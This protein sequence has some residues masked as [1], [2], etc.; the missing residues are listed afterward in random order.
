MHRHSRSSRPPKHR[1]HKT[2]HQIKPDA[3]ERSH[4][5]GPPAA[6]NPNLCRVAEETGR[7]IHQHETHFFNGGAV[8][9][10]GETMGGFMDRGHGSEEKPELD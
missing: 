9:F 7:K 4:N 10:A 8:M 5:A 2:D 3:C 6:E 1:G